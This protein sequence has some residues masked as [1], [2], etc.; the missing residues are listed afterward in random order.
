MKQDQRK[1]I[2]KRKQNQIIK[3]KTE[4]DNVRREACKRSCSDKASNRYTEMIKLKI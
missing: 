2:T 1:K 3:T 4:R